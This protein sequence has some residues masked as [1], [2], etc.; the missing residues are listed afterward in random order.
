MS[1][2]LPHSC[3]E[4]QGPGPGAGPACPPCAPLLAVH[5][6]WHRAALHHGQNL[7]S[8]SLQP[9]ANTHLASQTPE[10]EAIVLALGTQGP[11]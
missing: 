8:F 5:C 4:D 11:A 10:A 2:T 9:E 3:K 6:P 1:P 7:P